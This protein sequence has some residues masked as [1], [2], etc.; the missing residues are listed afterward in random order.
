M[1]EKYIVGGVSNSW[2]CSELIELLFENVYF[3][4]LHLVAWGC[5]LNKQQIKGLRAGGETPTEARL[6]CMIREGIQGSALD[7]AR[8]ENRLLNRA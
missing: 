2:I 5:Y 7:L 6:T 8:G 4:L 1:H 3:R